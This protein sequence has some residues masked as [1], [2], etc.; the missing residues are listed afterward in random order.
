V[1]A[2]KTKMAAF[3]MRVIL[4]L[5]FG[6]LAAPLRP[7]LAETAYAPAKPANTIVTVLTDGL[8]EPASEV[9]QI[10]SEVSI[11]LDKEGGVR[12][13]SINGY[14]GPANVRDLLQLRGTDFAVVNSDNLAYFDLA[15]ALPEAR[16][17]VR[18]V[19]PLFNQGVL[20]FGRTAIKSIGDLRGRKIGVPSSRPSRAVT[21]KTVFGL[22]KIE[23]N[24]VEL[25][26]EELAKQAGSLDGLAIYEKDLPL[27]QAWGVTPASHH[28]LPV[29][30]TESLAPVFLPKK[31][32]MPALAGFGAPAPLETIQV[33]TLLAAFDWNAKQGRYAD[34]VAFVEK[35]FATIPHLRAQYPDS[36][37]SRTDL[38]TDLPGWK[39]FGPAEAPAAAV[40]PVPAKDVR[41]AAVSPPKLQSPDGALKVAA[42]VRPP[43]TNDQDRGG[44]I[45]LKIFISA[46]NAAGIPVSIQ[47]TGSERE[48][49]SK[50]AS[51]AADAGVFWQSSNCEKPV[52]QSAIE[53]EL[54][55]GAILTDPL[56]QAVL[57]VFTR[58]DTPLDSNG[59]NATQSRVICV[60]DSYTMPEEVWAAI[61]WL[62]GARVKAVRPKTLIDCLA[63][64]DQREAD[65]LI[66]IEA[67]ARFAIE[68]L[69]LSQSFQISQRS[70]V[71]ASLHAVIAKDNP[72]QAQ[73]AQ[74]INEA[75]AKFKAGG[76][77]GD[78]M[79]SHLADLT[80]ITLKQPQ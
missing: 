31:I 28:L 61:P 73:L 36:P 70:P 63:A 11:A 79:A 44:G 2:A 14:G 48:L 76:A 51:K 52:N 71:A 69:K 45:A 1:R 59:A 43:L 57:A 77:Y 21:A 3:Q 33:T 24:F 42:V 37:F 58:I 46:L 41:A 29:T 19:A 74:I 16:R 54:C 53:A 26:D 67:E 75:L 8:G 7:A 80:G 10:L 34:A 6:L 50:I 22:L 25:S 68:K 72:R 20:F 55:D 9:S 56:M 39:R 65:A 27:L 13:L 78:I 62:K 64:V 38:K 32:A 23:A 15:K 40:P 30:V 35:F 47:W 66:A 49:L 12:L 60:P 5:I 4:L 17:K 18:L